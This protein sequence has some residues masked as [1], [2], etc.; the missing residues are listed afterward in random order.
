RGD[1]HRRR[2]TG[3]PP[4]RDRAGRAGHGRAPAPRRRRWTDPGTARP[5]P[6]PGR[7]PAGPG[8]PGRVG[9]PEPPSPSHLT[10]PG[11]RGRPHPPAPASRA[12]P[13]L[14]G[15]KYAR[16]LAQPTRERPNTRIFKAAH[17]RHLIYNTCWEDP[18]LDRVALDLGP[19]DRVMVITSAGCNALDYLLA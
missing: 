13:L 9:L 2:E 11:R 3:R 12:R 7:S 14:P 10:V 8:P 1:P 15:H 19:A 4:G 18:R 6:G 16:M 5:D 17:R